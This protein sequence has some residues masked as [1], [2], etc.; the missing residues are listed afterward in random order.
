MKEVKNLYLYGSGNRCKTL[1]NLLKESEYKICGIVDSN[2]EKWGQTIENI[3]IY[4]PAVLRDVKEAYVCVTFY[5]SLVN[6]PTWDL[7]VNV[8]NID[9]CRVLSFFDL[10]I[11]V[12][13]GKLKMDGAQRSLSYRKTF[14]DGT[15]PLLLGGVES[16]LK[17][18]TTE[19][20]EAGIRNVWLLTPLDESN[21]SDGIKDYV[22][23]LSFDKPGNF[24]MENIVKGINFLKTQLPF[25]IVFS[26]IDELMIAAF[27]LKEKYPEDIKIV[28]AVHGSCDGMYTDILCFR[29]MISEYVCVSHGIKDELIRRGVICEHIHTMTAPVD[30]D[31]NLKRTYTLNNREPLRI[32][33]AGRLEVF[34]KRLDILLKVISELEKT[35]V[36]YVLDIAGNGRYQDEIRRYTVEKELDN[37]V[38]LIGCIER[39]KIN[40]FWR[41]QDIAV[42]V[43]DNEGRPISNIE[44]MLNGTVPIVTNTVGSM[45]DVKDG[46]N[47]YI[48]PLCDY[49]SMAEKIKYIDSNRKAL[50]KLGRQA[51]EDMRQKINMEEYIEMWKKLI[52]E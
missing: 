31:R 34:E 21:I 38:R 49:K 12:Y 26:R 5:S 14:F 4:E 28:M 23:D 45:E 8:Y 15:W 7:I 52:L 40:E 48:V 13:R 19:F 50:P 37:K 29:T 33:Y 24:V 39:S 22:E 17:D 41:K 3:K 46:Q 27:L 25:T 2:S 20:K 36:N 30:Y 9:R 10:I 32:G 47:G 16:W 51:Y 44:A 43:S 1:L 6:E 11:E 42:N 35:D 18:I